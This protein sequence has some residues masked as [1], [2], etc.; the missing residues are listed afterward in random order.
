MLKNLLFISF[1]AFSSSTA[2][3]NKAPL[4]EP[5]KQNENQYEYYTDYIDLNFFEYVDFNF[6]SQPSYTYFEINASVSKEK[7]ELHALEINSFKY[8]SPYL[9]Q[10]NNSINLSVAIAGDDDQVD[11]TF[12]NERLINTL[13]KNGYAVVTDL[14]VN[15]NNDYAYLTKSWLDFYKVDYLGGD[16]RSYAITIT[17][18]FGNHGAPPIKWEQLFTIN[19]KFFNQNYY[20]KILGI[21]AYNNGYNDGLLDGYDN[22]YDNAYNDGFDI[23]YD[24]GL[25]AGYDNGYARGYN[26]GVA[27]DFNA[28]SWLTAVFS[29]MGALLSIQLLP[30]VTIGGIAVLVLVLTLLPFLIKLLKGDGE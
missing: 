20:D 11:Y 17:I 8:M 23:G 24:V 2:L 26:D 12:S 1:L 6:L 27:S 9:Y 16:N 18:P 21:N 19:L 13:D 4:N 30:G 25:G 22:G 7:V 14:A 28:W 3:S 5:Q 29:S 15:N 10:E